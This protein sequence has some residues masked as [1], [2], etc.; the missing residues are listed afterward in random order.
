M[1]ASPEPTDA[2]HEPEDRVRFVALMSAPEW[3]TQVRPFLVSVTNASAKRSIWVMKP[4]S[5]LGCVG[6]CIELISARFARLL[7]VKVPP[8]GVIDVVQEDLVLLD[9]RTTARLNGEI[10]PNFGTLMLDGYD[11]LH[12][13][14]AVPQE[15]WDDASS[16]FSLDVMGDNSDRTDD[17]SR[18]FVRSNILIGDRGLFAIDHQQMFS[19]YFLIPQAGPVWRD[20]MVIRA[21]AD[22]FLRTLIKA[23]SSTR[24]AEIKARLLGSDE[25]RVRALTDNL[26]PSWLD[27]GGETCVQQI[28]LF[29]EDVRQKA[30]SISQTIESGNSD[31]N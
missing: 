17:S 26:P 30:D 14:K 16:I 8:F 31:A 19:W 27:Q 28:A 1:S 15:H 9:R 29:L 11:D 22:H 13:P 12:D 3:E 25:D 4:R 21:K 5:R 2:G 20:S 6:S 23:S 18:G 24:R 7:G 10:G